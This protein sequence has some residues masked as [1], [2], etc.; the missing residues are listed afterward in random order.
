MPEREPDKQTEVDKGGMDRHPPTRMG[1]GDSSRDKR[2][3]GFCRRIVTRAK[4]VLPC[5]AAYVCSKC[6]RAGKR[7]PI[8]EGE[9]A[10]RIFAPWSDADVARANE[11][12]TSAKSLPFICT[13]GHALVAECGGYICPEC[14]Q[15]CLSWTYPWILDGSWKDVL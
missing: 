9:I 3:C 10:N 14:N 8:S 4:P 1:T 2:L 12:Q 5:M 15:T 11:Y 13:L 7:V 6:E